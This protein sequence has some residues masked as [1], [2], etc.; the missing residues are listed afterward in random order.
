LK[1]KLSLVFFVALLE[2][3]S[4]NGSKA[5]HYDNAIIRKTGDYSSA[6]LQNT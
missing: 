1:A 2:V 6:K 3:L 4:I 5:E